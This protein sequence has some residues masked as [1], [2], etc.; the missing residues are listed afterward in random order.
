M[1]YISQCLYKQETENDDDDHEWSSNFDKKGRIAGA[2]WTVQS[3]LP[4]GVNVRPHLTPAFLDPSESIFQRHLD[5][6][7]RFCWAHDRDRQTDQQT[8]LLR[9]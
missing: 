4:G 5:R 1:L 6:F 3:H 2:K 9:L 8:T 7:S